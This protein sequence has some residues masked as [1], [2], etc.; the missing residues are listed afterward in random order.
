MVGI[1][2]NGKGAVGHILGDREEGKLSLV[3]GSI[4]KR[5]KDSFDNRYASSPKYISDDI[6]NIIALPVQIKRGSK[7]DVPHSA[8]NP[9]LLNAP[10]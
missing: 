3:S 9:R 2:R 4:S 10:L 5:E 7:N 8:T 6:I 1:F